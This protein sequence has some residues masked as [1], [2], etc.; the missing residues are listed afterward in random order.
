MQE[1]ET[2]SKAEL[3]EL[4]KAKD[5]CRKVGHK[6]YPKRKGSGITATL[7]FDSFLCKPPTC[8]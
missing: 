7:E 1:R 2:I 3:I 4:W 6:M 5:A 8:A